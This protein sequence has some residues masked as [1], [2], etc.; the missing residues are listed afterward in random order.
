MLDE[1]LVTQAIQR[2]ALAIF[3]IHK[4]KMTKEKNYF[5]V[6]LFALDIVYFTI[7]PIMVCARTCVK[8]Y[9]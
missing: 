8:S 3:L 5:H 4:Y 1:K 2:I 9:S 6:S 7:F